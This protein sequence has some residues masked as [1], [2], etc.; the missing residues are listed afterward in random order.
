[1]A[2]AV[3]VSVLTCGCGVQAGCGLQPGNASGTVILLDYSATFA[4]Y[5]AADEALLREIQSAL[6][7]MIRGGSLPQPAK[8]IWSA[9]G[10][11][12]VNPLQ[13][14]GPPR[15]FRQR[16]IRSI[17]PSTVEGE[18][19]TVEQLQAWFGACI[20]TILATSSRTEQ[21]TDL[22]GALMFAANA[23][24][25]ARD[26]KLIVVF[27]DLREDVPVGRSA[28]PLKLAAERILL[29][30]R[31]GLDDAKDPT[32]VSVRAEEW[33]ERLLK[34]GASVVCARPSQGLTGADIGR[35]LARQ[36]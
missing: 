4:P 18:I 22:S 30:S 11:V 5:T 2:V 36:E 19:P 10:S 6:L 25:D 13:P 34:S 9:F 29:V 32:A 20:K 3:L 16:I 33:R 8:V 1:M 12:G 24:Q 26:E 28:V 7:G 15:T 23:V 21:Y 17:L 31:P 14:C 27:S 35:C